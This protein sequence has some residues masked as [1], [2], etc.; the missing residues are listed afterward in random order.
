[1][2][3]IDGADARLPEANQDA[4]SWQALLQAQEFCRLER[5]ATVT[6]DAHG[7]IT[8]CSMAGAH[9]LG[10]AEN[11]MG[12]PLSKFLDHLPFGHNTPGYNLAYAVFHGADG[13]WQRHTTA[14]RNGQVIGV[15]VALSS[16]MMNG[17][18]AIKLTLK[19]ADS[20]EQ[21]HCH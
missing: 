16:V 15:D 8:D 10:S 9:L 13:R 3:T 12:K 17:N 19:A 21:A 6:I 11:L 5:D 7:C 2:N 14:A 20:G 18:R 4:H 1:M